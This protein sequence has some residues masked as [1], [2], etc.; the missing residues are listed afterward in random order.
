MRKIIFLNGCGSSGKTSITRSIQHL[1][2]ELW[3]TF[4]IDSFID[5]MPFGKQ[6]SYLKFIQGENECGMKVRV[7][8]QPKGSDLFNAMPDFAKLLSD[9]G[10]NIIIDEVLLEDKQLQQYAQKLSGHAVYLVGVFCDLQV[11]QEREI[12]RRDRCIGLSNDQFDRVHL[13]LRANYD[14]KVDTTNTSSFEVARQILAYVESNTSPKGF[15]K[16][17]E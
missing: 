13:G 1:S 17:L 5:M 7:E 11:M 16:I 10:H 15:K 6:E 4:G 12:L 3:L 9:K 8:T 2:E 14:L